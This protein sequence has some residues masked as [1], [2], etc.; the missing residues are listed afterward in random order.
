MSDNIACYFRIRLERGLSV[1]RYMTGHF[2]YT[3][4]QRE[5][6]KGKMLDPEVMGS[7]STWTWPGCIGVVTSCIPNLPP[8]FVIYH[9]TAM[10]LNV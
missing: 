7:I 4:A 3:G 8:V 2:I 6:V 10:G 5:N 1:K 9:H